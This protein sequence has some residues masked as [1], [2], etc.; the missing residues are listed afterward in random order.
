MAHRK[1]RI[2]L[3][4]LGI[5]FDFSNLPLPPVAEGGYQQDISRALAELSRVEGGEE[6]N[7]DEHRMVGHYWL[8]DPGRAPTPEIRAEIQAELH[9]VK[10]FWATQASHFSTVVW[11]GIGGS[12]LGPQFLQAAFHGVHAPTFVFLD[13]TDIV[14]MCDALSGIKDLSRTLFVAVSKSGSTTETQNCLQV[15]E[16]YCARHNIAF[17]SRAVAITRKGSTLDTAAK[18]WLERFQL[19]DWVGG[20]T[21]VWTSIGTLPLAMLGQDVDDFL[22]GAC[23]MDACTRLDRMEENPALLLALAWSY[24]KACGRTKSFVVLPYSDRLS[25]LAQYCQQLIMESVGKGNDRSGA[26]VEEGITVLGNKGSTDQHAYVQQ[27]REGTNDFIAFF[28]EVIHAEK[29]LPDEF[30]ST[31]LGGFLVNDYL[32]GFLHGT[33]RALFENGRGNCLLSMDTI[34]PRTIGALLAFLERSVGFY[35]AMHN[36]NAY[37]QPGVEAG[38]KAAKEVLALQDDLVAALTSEP[39]SWREISERFSK[40]ADA[41]TLES[42]V[43]RLVLTG[44]VA[45]DGK[46]KERQYRYIGSLVAGK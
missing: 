44:R 30:C 36:V 29:G 46:G 10:R 6:V 43:R 27:L 18:D 9:K 28:V 16:Q 19:W 40:K 1:I 11:L 13:N 24:S 33:R 7:T 39:M 14:G 25:L 32:L 23:D 22:Q 26:T 42:V 34:T 15:C 2:N 12:A 35:A 41:A 45:E 8:R 20:R 21:S 38:K 37:N 3:Q 31:K 17:Q 4:G 5:R